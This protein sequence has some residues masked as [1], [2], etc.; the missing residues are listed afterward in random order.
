MSTVV[1]RGRGLDRK[2]RGR[3]SQSVVSGRGFVK[4]CEG[5]PQLAVG[6]ISSEV[7][8]L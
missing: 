2:I 7:V 1:E 8:L 6:V 3:S 4:A 5:Y